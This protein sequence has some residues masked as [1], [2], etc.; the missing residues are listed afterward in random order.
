MPDSFDAY[1]TLK[2]DPEADPEVIQAAYRRLA[3]KYHPDLTPDVPGGERMTAINRAW[4]ILRDPGRR[5]AYD[6]ERQASRR[7]TISRETGAASA[8]SQ[9]GAGEP[10][11]PSGGRAGK[12][13]G[14]GSSA[15][16][17]EVSGNWTSGRSNVGG[18]YDPASMGM[19]QGTG[20]AGAP[21][22]NPSGS[23]LNFGRYSGWSLGE[24]ARR[25]LE[26]IEWLDRT[27]IGRPY[28]EE[29]DTLLRA[30]GRR[31]APN[32]EA[33]ERRGLFRRR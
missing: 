19:A 27:P 17:E 15:P 13:P 10:T 11:R 26:Y 5:A 14:S 31:R 1:K 32:V 25:D 21:P 24:V 8:G 23:V 33:S 3:Q 28:R 30:S 16:V 6:L 20:A 7:S 18:G 22:G 29:I 9:S 2:V 12:R 4:E